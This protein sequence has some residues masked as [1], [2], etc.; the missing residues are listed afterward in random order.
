MAFGD[1]LIEARKRRKLSQEGLA[2]I[3]NVSQQAISFIEQGKRSPTE[4]TMKLLAA[5]L[6][7]DV[8]DLLDDAQ[9]KPTPQDELK[10]SNAV[11]LSELSNS[12]SPQEWQ[13]VLAFVEG[14]KA[15]RSVQDSPDR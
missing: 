1:K 12:L 6:D 15:A 3:S 5:A 10:E 13:Q 2:K 11:M 8:S 7:L 14:L 9:K 4:E